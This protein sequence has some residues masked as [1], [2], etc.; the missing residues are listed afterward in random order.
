MGTTGA[1]YPEQLGSAKMSA[2]ERALR[3]LVTVDV[4]G[5][6]IVNAYRDVERFS[7]AVP[8]G[9][10][11]MGKNDVWIAAT[12]IVTGQALITTDTDFKH[13][14]GH[15]LQVHMVYKLKPYSDSSASQVT[16]SA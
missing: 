14:D 5:R 1:C 3:E 8:T 15:L 16:R 7:A 11:Q 6:N 10:V 2:L 9:A 12:A 4:A 13:L